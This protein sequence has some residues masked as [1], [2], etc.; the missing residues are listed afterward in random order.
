M[1]HNLLQR[2]RQASRMNQRWLKILLVTVSIFTYRCGGAPTVAPTFTPTPLSIRTNPAIMVVKMPMRITCQLP[3]DL[4]GEGTFVFGVVGT[5]MEQGPIDNLQYSRI[6]TGACEPIRIVCGYTL[7]GE[8]K[9][10][11]KYLD[12]EPNGDCGNVSRN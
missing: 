12:L 3:T 6:V 8:S 11:L 5:F 10:T 2:L 7:S 4:K 9:A 1:A